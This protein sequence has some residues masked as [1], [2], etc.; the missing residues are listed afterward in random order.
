MMQA[1]MAAAML[2][3]LLPGAPQVC[4][5][6]HARAVWRS[7]LGRPIAL[8][9]LL[10]CSL[11]MPLPPHTTRPLARAF[12]PLNPMQ[13]RTS[14]AGELLCPGLSGFGAERLVP[15]DTLLGLACLACSGSL[16]QRLGVAWWAADRCEAARFLAFGRR[17]AAV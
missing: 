12:P 6:R 15:V 7:K 3:E 5:Q 16:A 9:H 1:G 10:P 13:L 17:G 2:Q 4:K 11:P 14:E 8:A